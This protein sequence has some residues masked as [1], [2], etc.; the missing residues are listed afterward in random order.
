MT[1]SRIATFAAAAWD[2]PTVRRAAISAAVVAVAVSS[3][4]G[5]D[6]FVV[7]FVGVVFSPLFGIDL[8]WTYTTWLFPAL[9]PALNRTVEDDEADQC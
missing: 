5:L 3:G 8:L 6:L 4:R 7:T 1:A 2:H 9:N